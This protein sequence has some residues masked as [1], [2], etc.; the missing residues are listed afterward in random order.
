M[1]H[2]DSPI[3]LRLMTQH[4]ECPDAIEGLEVAATK[5]NVA[6]LRVY[7][8]DERVVIN[9][10]HEIRIGVLRSDCVAIRDRLE[11]I[12]GRQDETGPLTG[13]VVVPAQTVA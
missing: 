4:F 6:C 9:A 12:V 1:D 3:P 2:G 13:M 8:R 11:P 5:P 10:G 7:L